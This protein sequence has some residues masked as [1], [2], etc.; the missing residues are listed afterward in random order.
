M[1]ERRS[2]NLKETSLIRDARNSLL[3]SQSHECGL[4]TEVGPGAVTIMC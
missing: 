2:D 1:E 3:G 4:C